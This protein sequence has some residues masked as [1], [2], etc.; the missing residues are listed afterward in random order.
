MPVRHY[1]FH[2]ALCCLASILL[3]TGCRDRGGSSSPAAEATIQSLKSL[4]D[5]PDTAEVS[6]RLEKISDSLSKRKS[7][8]AVRIALTNAR[9]EL[10]RRKELP[11]SGFSVMLQGMDLALVEEDSL[12][13]AGVLMDMCLWKESEQRFSAARS[14][15]ARSLA[16]YRRKGRP[17]EVT[18]ALD[19]TARQLQHLGDLPGAHSMMTEALQMYEREG[20]VK[21]TA[22]ACNI[23]GNNYADLGEVD[24]AMASYR[25]S[26]AL[27][28]GLQDSGRLCS[29]YSNI[30]ILYRYSNPDSAQYYY[31]IAL[32]LTLNPRYRF[33]YVIGL[34]NKA[35]VHFDQ[36]QYSEAR[37]IYDTVMVLCERHQ[38]RDGIPRV[39]SGYAYLAEASNDNKTWRMYLARARGMA[40]SMGQATLALWLRKEE[41]KAAEKLRDI[42]SVIA[43]SNDI[44]RRE[45]SIAGISKKAQVAEVDMQ[46]NM[47]GRE[48]EIILLRTKLNARQWLIGLLACLTVA[49]TALFLL[50]RRQRRVLAERNRSFEAQIARYQMDRDR[51]MTPGSTGDLYPPAGES[52][53]PTSGA[54]GDTNASTH[55]G[56]L[57]LDDLDTDYDRILYILQHEKLYLRPRLKVEDLAE[58]TGISVRKLPEVLK[59]EGEDG[60]NAMLNRF[61]IAEATRLMEDPA[62][63]EI[64]FGE[65]AERCGFS[66]RQHFYRVFEQ[67]TGVNP[68]YYRERQGAKNG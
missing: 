1:L 68:G 2:A 44:R 52:E 37:R 10:L 57:P 49:M 41:L 58:R 13:L 16:I 40:D 46:Y 29:A 54:E 33:Q 19:A 53:R 17:A 62:S 61:R 47:L 67:V 25:R 31:D 8:V 55:G 56:T 21:K 4:A 35:N 48:R 20:N 59:A 18:A 64:T 66:S 6:R 39:L 63:R 22:E 7:P 11:D 36:R 32:K 30:G 14:F 23:I 9:A 38:F 45:D 12:A 26:A 3:V 51:M 42:D 34:F 50:Y 65:L 28:M 43:V 60:F 5:L 15:A 24:K 27:S